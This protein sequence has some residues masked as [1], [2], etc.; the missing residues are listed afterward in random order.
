MDQHVL[1][2]FAIYV[3]AVY[4]LIR[5]R[6]Y[7]TRSTF[8][9]SLGLCCMSIAILTTIYNRRAKVL[10]M[11]RK[12]APVETFIASP[13]INYNDRVVNA[14]FKE[15]LL[16]DDSLG[17]LKEGLVYYISSFQMQN[18][19]FE[20]DI[21]FNAIDNKIAAVVQHSMLKNGFTQYLGFKVDS[22]VV[23][24]PCS[25]IF[26]NYHNF[27]I[28]T[29]FSLGVKMYK[30]SMN[31]NNNRF[32]LLT[33]Y[34]NNVMR[35]T[36]FLEVIFQY[37]SNQLNP[38]IVLKFHGENN[39]NKLA[40]VTYTYKFEDYLASKI[41]ADGNYH[42]MTIVK[43]NNHVKLYMDEY[44]LINCNNDQ[45]YNTSSIVLSDGDNEIQPSDSP[46]RINY[47]NPV[48]FWFWMSNFGIYPNRVLTNTEILSL[49]S[50]CKDTHDSLNPKTQAIIQKMQQ[51]EE[52]VEQFSKVCPYPDHIRDS[53]Y[54]RDV[55]NWRSVDDLTLDNRCF[56][57]INAYCN[58]NRAENPVGCAFT[59][60][61]AVFKM[62][63]TIDPNLH[64]YNDENTEGNINA[65]ERKRIA[66]LGLKDM[67][68]DK[69]IKSPN[70][71]QATNLNNTIDNL[72]E[73]NQLVGLDTGVDM[74][75]S[76][77]E[78]GKKIDYDAL[79]D[80]T[81]NVSGDEIPTFEELYKHLLT[82]E[83]ATKETF[84][85]EEEEDHDS[86]NNSSKYRAIMQAYKSRKLANAR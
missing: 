17:Y 77:A 31:V 72:L 13:E 56:K 58:D 62:A 44:V 21:I 57:A 69:S 3:F 16:A 33:L 83:L 84:V 28:F 32:T 52:A 60:K 59:T 15:K 29:H 67:Y 8:E 81:A 54:C 38:N 24:Y 61:D 75:E 37:N 27:T 78:I 7:G 49:H 5:W 51:A 10:V 68:L 12:V 35:T 48:N 73:T 14:N 74:D 39:S 26:S 23:C 85:V 41:F 2:Q 45:C 79:L 20:K 22:Q 70:G 66:R 19:D 82:S 25:K 18:I 80:S 42:T 34:T 43:N 30:S 71:R 86:G 63:S 64:Y 76:S 55:K 1:L 6:I 65:I 4:F 40:G 46:F 50:Y 53:K 9:L 47:D 36:R 11:A